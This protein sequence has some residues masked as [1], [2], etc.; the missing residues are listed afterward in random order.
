MVRPR[1]AWGERAADRGA[2][3]TPVPAGAAGPA[4][5]EPPGVRPGTDP[6]A[7]SRALAG[8][9]RSLSSSGANQAAIK[10]AARARPRMS[11]FIGVLPLPLLCAPTKQTEL[12]PQF[13]P[14]R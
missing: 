9:I 11:F 13:P 14:H 7:A 10:V 2:P 3:G 5:T 4:V 6:C 1:S 8:A 12:V